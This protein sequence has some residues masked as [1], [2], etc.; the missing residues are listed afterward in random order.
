MSKYIVCPICG[1]DNTKKLFEKQDCSFVQ[2]MNDSLVYVNPQPETKDLKDIYDTYGK[3]IH[4]TADPIAENKEYNEFGRYFHAFRETNHLLEIGCAAG[5]FLLRC[6]NDGWETYGAELSKPS[7]E[8]ARNE[9]GLDVTTGTIHDAK[10]PKDFF[11]VICL[12]KTLEHVPDPHEVLT[13][14]HRILRKGGVFYLSVPSWNGLGIRLIGRKHQY[15]GRDHLFYFTQ[16]NIKKLLMDV[17]FSNARTFTKG[18]NV[19]GVFRS[20]LK[21]NLSSTEECTVGGS[22]ASPCPRS[23]LRRSCP[24]FIKSS[25]S[26]ALGLFNLGDAL[27]VEAIK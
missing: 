12:W 19:K 23:F 16:K 14:I 7:S 24:Q 9:R 25:L 18:F 21:K 17:G 10:Y 27:Y 2:C 26:R 15:I 8:Y 13:E 6:R 20:I 3:A 4:I 11:D 1:C 5:G 22:E